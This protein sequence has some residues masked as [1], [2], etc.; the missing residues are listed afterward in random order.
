MTG[1]CE[2]CRQ[3]RDANV[4]PVRASELFG[5]ISRQFVASRAPNCQL[6]I[7]IE[8]VVIL[9]KTLVAVLRVERFAQHRCNKLADWRAD[10]RG[11]GERG[12]PAD[13]RCGADFAAAACARSTSDAVLRDRS[14]D[15]GTRG[16][17]AA[18][19]VAPL[20]ERRQ[21]VARRIRGEVARQIVG[22][23]M[24]RFT[25]S[26][27]RAGSSRIAVLGP[28]SAVE[29]ATKSTPTSSRPPGAGLRIALVQSTYAYLGARIS[30]SAA[31]GIRQELLS[32][33][34]GAA[35]L[36]LG[37]Y[38]CGRH[39][40]RHPVETEQPTSSARFVSPH[41]KRGRPIRQR[42]VKPW[43]CCGSMDYR[44]KRPQ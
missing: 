39:R 5:Q 44:P 19:A 42:N 26:L 17:Q 29:L 13:R 8:T 21:A 35:E 37:R 43:R 10:G 23:A 20:P 24:N 41:G 4:S 6:K 16:Q 12:L 40:R 15:R 14:V 32:A 7:A 18:R 28:R 25:E 33:H 3:P 30:R 34:Q 1:V 27:S 36:R 9:T 38:G 31:Q 2:F 22:K 11:Q